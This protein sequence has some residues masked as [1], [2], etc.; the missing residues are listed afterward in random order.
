MVQQRCAAKL[1]QSAQ[2]LTDFAKYNRGDCSRESNR[3][4]KLDSMVGGASADQVSVA[5][6]LRLVHDHSC[7]LNARTVAGRYHVHTR[8]KLQL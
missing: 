7:M 6:A 3:L 1:V 4:K 8:L 2:L 5:A